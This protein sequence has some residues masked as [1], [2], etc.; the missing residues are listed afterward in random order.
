M[1]C[2]SEDVD[3]LFVLTVE[4]FHFIVDRITGRLK[5]QAKSINILL[6]KKWSRSASKHDDF[7]GQ[8]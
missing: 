6:E 7:L 4:D 2:Y 3:S 5:C 8:N 1:V